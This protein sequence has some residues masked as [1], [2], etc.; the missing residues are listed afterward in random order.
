MP[1]SGLIWDCHLAVALAAGLV[2]VWIKAFADITVAWTTCGVSPPP[3]RARLVN[4]AERHPNRHE[5]PLLLHLLSL[6]STTCGPFSLGCSSARLSGLRVTPEISPDPPTWSHSMAQ[7]NLVNIRRCS[8]GVHWVFGYTQ[9]G[10]RM[11]SGHTH[12]YSCHHSNLDEKHQKGSGPTLYW[13]SLPS[14]SSTS[15]LSTAPDVYPPVGD[16]GSEK[17]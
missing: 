15:T 10:A 11:G 7:G 13:H 5:P 3:T 14:N 16:D 17:M 6:G 4:P 12:L 1:Q 9:T 8:R 2:A